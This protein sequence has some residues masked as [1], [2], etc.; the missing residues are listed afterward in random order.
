MA[1]NKVYIETTVISYLTSRPSKDP[2]IAG[3]QV[4]TREWWENRKSLFDLVVSE[5]A[6]QEASEGDQEAAQQRLNHLS[7]MVSLEISEEAIALAKILVKEG[8]IPKEYGEDALHISICAINGIDFLVTWNCRHLAN[9]V[10]RHQIE[11][12]VESQGYL[13]PVICT[14]EELMEE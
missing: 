6:F 9:A 11:T 4:L 12:V 13:C 3:R 7:N 1:R 5:L 14:P 10:H 8:P 2:I